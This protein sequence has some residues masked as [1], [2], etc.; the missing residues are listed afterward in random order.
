MKKVTYTFN[1]GVMLYWRHYYCV[2]LT[3]NITAGHKKA[4]TTIYT[5]CPNW[6]I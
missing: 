6:T 4:S 2:L 3:S 1:L 5:G